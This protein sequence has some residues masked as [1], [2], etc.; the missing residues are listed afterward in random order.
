MR[1]ELNAVS[2]PRMVNR[3]PTKTT[4]YVRRISVRRSAPVRTITPVEY[5][6]AP[7]LGPRK[8]ILRSEKG[9]SGNKYK[10]RGAGSGVREVLTERP[11]AVHRDW[12]A[13]LC[14]P[15]TR[16]LDPGR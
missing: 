11:A 2:T 5:G 16:T 3:M 7:I 8:A 13:G 9:S 14:H 10:R 4:V 1:G 12:P 15:E 6:T